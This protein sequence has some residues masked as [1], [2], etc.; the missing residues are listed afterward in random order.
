MAEHKRLE[1]E[2]RGRPRMLSE[3]MLEGFVVSRE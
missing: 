3:G 1:A 2:L